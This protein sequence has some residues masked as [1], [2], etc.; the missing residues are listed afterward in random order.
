MFF[1]WGIL[2]AV[3]GFVVGWLLCRVRMRSRSIQRHPA[4][5]HRV[6]ERRVDE[7]RVDE[8][9]VDEQRL[10]ERQVDER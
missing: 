4:R 9:R 7:R 8:R 6:D 5:T 10:D 2:M 3:V 1:L